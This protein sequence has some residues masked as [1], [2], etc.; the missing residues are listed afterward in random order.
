MFK[1][2]EDNTRGRCL[3]L[4]SLGR[5]STSGNDKGKTAAVSELAWSQCGQAADARTS[6]IPNSKVAM[7]R[8]RLTGEVTGASNRLLY[9]GHL[10][11]VGPVSSAV[12]ALV[13]GLPLARYTDSRTWTSCNKISHIPICRLLTRYSRNLA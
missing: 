9:Y 4:K 12:E 8:E 13:R 5:T 11:G 1:L 10:S 7:T 6:H 2:K 3:I